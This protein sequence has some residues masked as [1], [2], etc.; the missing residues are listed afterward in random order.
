MNTSRVAHLRVAR[1]DVTIRSIQDRLRQCAHALL[2]K[3]P[4][5][6]VTPT[7]GY[8]V[9]G[10]Q[11]S[12]SKHCFGGRW[13]QLRQIACGSAAKYLCLRQLFSSSFATGESPIGEADP[14]QC[15]SANGSMTQTPVF[16]SYAFAKRTLPTSLSGLLP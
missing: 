9:G 5:D 7:L 8:L 15:T 1:D 14:P 10:E 12:A 2:M 4:T 6:N 11:N 13:R 16:R 3:R